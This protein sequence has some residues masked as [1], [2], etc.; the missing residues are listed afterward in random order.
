MACHVQINPTAE[1]L[2][3]SHELMEV[4]EEHVRDFEIRYCYLEP[5][6]VLIEAL[7]AIRPQDEDEEKALAALRRELENGEPVELLVSC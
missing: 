7:R 2:Q 6:P 1:A 4:L 3:V 5:E